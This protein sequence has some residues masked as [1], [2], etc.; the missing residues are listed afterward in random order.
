MYFST[1]QHHR[2]LWPL[3]SIR[4]TKKV[5]FSSLIYPG[6]DQASGTQ[7]LPQQRKPLQKEEQVPLFFDLLK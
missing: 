7:I 2:K 3:G 4:L 1:Q 5:F 6:I